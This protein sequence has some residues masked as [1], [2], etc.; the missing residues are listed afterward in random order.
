MQSFHRFISQKSCSSFGFSDIVLPQN[1]PP[2]IRYFG[3]AFESRGEKYRFFFKAMKRLF[4]IILSVAGL[5]FVF[6]LCL[7]IWVII[8]FDSSGRVLIKQKR[9]GKD[10]EIFDMY[11]FRTMQKNSGLYEKAPQTSNDKRITKP[12]RFLRKTGLDEIPQLINVLKGQM[13]LVGPRPEMPFIVRNYSELQRKRL[14]VKPGLTGLWQ[15]LGRK[16]L[17]IHENIEYDFYYIKNQSLFLDMVILLKTIPAV[18]RGKG[19]F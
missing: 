12:G 2:A 16:D 17:P 11:K 15:I 1:L 3:R 19:G 18:I 6:P 13:S 8:R 9:V 7:F 5:I 10:G 14:A 4:D